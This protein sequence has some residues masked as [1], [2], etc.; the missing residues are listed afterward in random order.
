MCWGATWHLVGSAECAHISKGAV[1]QADG[2]GPPSLELPSDWASWVSSPTPGAPSAAGQSPRSKSFSRM[3][4]G[5]FVVDFSA[6]PALGRAP[7]PSPPRS[8]PRGAAW[9]DGAP[10]NPPT[11]VP[12]GAWGAVR[13]PEGDSPP[14]DFGDAPRTASEKGKAGK[15]AKKKLLL[16]SSSSRAPYN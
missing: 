15:K 7:S 3:V 9:G 1:H 12:S 4:E 8:D 13:P 16:Y 14:L 6:E 2:D 5:G 11:S 10:A